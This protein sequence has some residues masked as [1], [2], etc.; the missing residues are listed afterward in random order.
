MEHV[1]LEN[2]T[3]ARELINIHFYLN[4]LV[5]ISCVFGYTLYFLRLS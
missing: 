1:N 4:Y 3:L 5:F 2:V